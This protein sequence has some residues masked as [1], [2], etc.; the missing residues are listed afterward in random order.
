MLTHNTAKVAF[1]TEGDVITFIESYEHI[2][3]TS[4]TREELHLRI[5]DQ[6]GRH[7]G[8]GTWHL[9]HKRLSLKHLESMNISNVL[10]SREKQ[11]IDALKMVNLYREP[12]RTCWQPKLAVA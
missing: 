6:D 7:I 1:M 5:N 9:T 3:I 4:R 10:T 2:L 8:T 11:V 12:P